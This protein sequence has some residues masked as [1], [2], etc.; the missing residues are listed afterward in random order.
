M[1]LGAFRK[2]MFCP[3]CGA[4]NRSDQN[5]CRSC[6]LKLG[7]ITRFVSEQFPTEEYAALQR[8]KER[9]E[10][11]GFV[12]LS[13]FA[14]LGFALLLVKAAY[15][16]IIL[17]GPDVIFGAAFAAMIVFGLLSVVFFNYPKL[18]MN[19]DKVNH[20]LPGLSESGLA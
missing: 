20:R 1:N 8:R 13:L 17:F 18:F 11:L 6:G 3:N 2:V 4:K 16:K 15:E 9:F 5:Y 7:E 10:K 19:F 12:S 14:F